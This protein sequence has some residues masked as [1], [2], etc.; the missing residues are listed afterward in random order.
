MKTPPPLMKG[1]YKL[2]A[3]FLSP[4]VND[5]IQGRVAS[6]A[7]RALLIVGLFML[8]KTCSR[9]KPVLNDYLVKVCHCWPTYSSAK[10]GLIG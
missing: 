4:S 3:V 10:R 7:L 1:M 8:L 6:F 2:A 9:L 5:N